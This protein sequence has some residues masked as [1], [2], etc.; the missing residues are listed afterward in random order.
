MVR[1]QW[2]PEDREAEWVEEYA[3]LLGKCSETKVIERAIKFY[4]EKG[5]TRDS[6]MKDQYGEKRV[7]EAKKRADK[8]TQ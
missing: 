3:D 2:T 5:A 7:K 6:V 4:R 1:K 8:R